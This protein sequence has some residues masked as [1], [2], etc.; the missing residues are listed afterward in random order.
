MSLPAAYG[1]LTA[2]C[3]E[4]DKV[5]PPEWSPQASW[6]TNTDI[7]PVAGM[8]RLSNLR[9][10]PFVAF[11]SM[12]LTV[13]GLVLLIASANVSNLLLARPSPPRHPLPTQLPPPA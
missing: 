7:V 1:R 13:V 5:Y 11:F 12:L 10:V 6:V 2:A 9:M 4:L 3:E 8:A